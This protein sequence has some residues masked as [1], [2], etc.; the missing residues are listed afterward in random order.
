MTVFGL[1]LSRYRPE[2]WITELFRL[3]S[4]PISIRRIM[5][6]GRRDGDADVLI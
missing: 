5:W 1:L 3:F 6:T 4:R 2:T